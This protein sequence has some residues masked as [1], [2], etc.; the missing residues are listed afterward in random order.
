MV[1]PYFTGI[2]KIVLESLGNAT[3]EIVVAIYWFTNHELFDKLC[4][5]V[6][7]GIKV[8]LIV[9]NDYINNRETGLD[10]Q[11]FID[12]G[13][14][15]FFSTSDNPMHNKFCVIDN[16]TLINGSYNWTYFAETK[17]S[18]NILLIRDEVEAI[19]AF[20]KEFINLTEQLERVDKIQL[21]TKFELDE[22]NA[23]SARDYLASDIVYEA[24]ATNRPELIE[25]AFRLS[26]TNLKVQEIA[27]RL[28]LEKKK[29]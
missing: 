1:I 15:F 9:H 20:R 12:L 7:E 26:P 8:A 13:G 18:E 11:S 5:K 23:L 4:E 21:L 27:V 6:R 14:Q 16:K 24:K 25:T 17:N 19:S 3:E 28:D 22:F 29:K 2:R 10:F